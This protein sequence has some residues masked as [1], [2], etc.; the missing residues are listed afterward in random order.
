MSPHLILITVLSGTINNLPHLWNQ[1]EACRKEVNAIAQP[2]G[3]WARSQY[4]VCLTPE[5]WFSITAYPASH[6]HC[7]RDGTIMAEAPSRSISG[8]LKQRYQDDT[9]V[10]KTQVYWTVR[11]LQSLPC[12]SLPCW[13]PAP[14]PVLKLHP[15][16]LHPILLYLNSLPSSL[17]SL[18]PL[19]MPETLS[20]YW[21]HY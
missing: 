15:C 20:T 8:I 13:Y 16:L 14:V 6:P 18:L 3:S 11:S 17:K 10:A 4:R 9:Q 1:K 12:L 5:P 2:L 21:S 19:A 7:R